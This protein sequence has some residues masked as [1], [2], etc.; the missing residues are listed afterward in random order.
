[1]ALHRKD[2]H[3]EAGSGRM[4]SLGKISMLSYLHFLEDSCAIYVRLCLLQSKI[5]HNVRQNMIP[6]LK[7][8]L[9][10][11]IHGVASPT[12]REDM[13]EAI[14]S[15]PDKMEPIA[16]DHWFNRPF[17]SPK[18]QNMY[19]ADNNE[20]NIMREAVAK[21]GVGCASVCC[22]GSF[23]VEAMLSVIIDKEYRNLNFDCIER[24]TMN[25]MARPL[26]D[27]IPLMIPSILRNYMESCRKGIEP[28]LEK[29]TVTWVGMPYRTGNFPEDD[30]F[31]DVI[32]FS[33][34]TRQYIKVPDIMHQDAGKQ[35]TGIRTPL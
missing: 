20:H 15:K 8:H 18:Y 4:P 5:L 25:N 12:I 19:L 21:S 34:E 23:I 26:Y 33:A 30:L 28:K 6:I 24:T 1:M 3:H 10:S 17:P 9:A 16:L 14:F 35:T 22:S 7:R 13:V 2:R 32:D 11:H 31:E 29:L 27:Q